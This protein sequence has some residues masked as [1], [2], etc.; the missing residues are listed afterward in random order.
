MK[1]ETVSLLTERLDHLEEEM[2]FIR[3]EL[4]ELR[5]QASD[6][7]RASDAIWADKAAQK[8]AANDLFAALSIRG[9]PIGAEALQQQMAQADLDEDELSKGI[10]EAREE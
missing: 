6:E 3:K 5:Q 9:S 10:I 1:G 7:S 2:R 8:R 4:D